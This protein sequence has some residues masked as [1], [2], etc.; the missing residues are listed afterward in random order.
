MTKRILI[1]GGGFAG[2]YTAM[3]LEKRLAGV[4]DVEIFLATQENFL[5]FTPMLHE[6]AGA[7]VNV[8]DVVQALRKMLRRTRIAIVDIE[9]I[10]LPRKRVR[11]LQ[12]DL[13]QS[14]EL[15]YDQLVLSIGAVTNF[16]RTPGMEEHALTMK[17]LGDAILLRNRVIEALE[18]ADS[19]PDD[20]ERKALLTVA[21]AGAG[22]A[23]VETAGAVNDLMRGAI[24]FYPH[25]NEEM[26]RIVLVSSGDPVLPEL[27]PSLGRYAVKAMRRRRVEIRLNSQATAYDGRE[28]TLG[29]GTTI[30]TRLVVWTAGITPSPL[31]SKLPCKLERG[32]VVTDAC[33]AV[34][35]WPGVWSLGDC[36]YV[37]DILNPGSHF[38]PTA[39]HAIREAPV[40]ADNIVA[41]LQGR[42]PRPF[43]FKT[44]GMLAT[45]GRRA[46]VA[47]ILGFRFSGIVAWLL[48]RSIY[49]GKLPGLQK[50]IRVAMD[51]ALDLVFSKDIVQ[52]PTLPAK[53]MSEGEVLPAV[54]R[55][56]SRAPELTRK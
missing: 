35:G 45:I 24:P 13:Q 22:F 34:P 49:L 41:Q 32:M 44:L 26:L 15:P 42:P 56:D 23:G 5:L 25:L 8:T 20:N 31:L 48:W 1:L 6:V 38:P 43:R 17:T 2:A 3:H 50:K 51:W 11:F 16:H 19:H 36:A 37:P 28:L 55:H 47:E 33:L 46:G 39:Q 54:D 53:T 4:P 10:D 40:V 18:L 29:D 30:D 7:D 27:S 9:S 14:F 12:P 52:L 21:V